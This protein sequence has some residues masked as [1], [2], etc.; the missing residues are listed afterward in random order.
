MVAF[1]DYT[2]RSPKSPVLVGDSLLVASIPQTLG[3]ARQLAA[4]SESSNTVL[5][6]T[7]TRLRLT[8]TG[9]AMRY[10]IG[11]TSQTASATSHYLGLDQSID[12]ALPETPNIAVMRIGLVSGVMEVS[13]LS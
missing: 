10:S 5:T 3:L 9:C 12:I 7:A 4:G 6:P 2:T 8:A 13:E 1:L 11:S